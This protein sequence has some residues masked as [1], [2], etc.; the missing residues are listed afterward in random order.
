MYLLGG[1]VPVRGYLRHHREM[2]GAHAICIHDRY[3]TIKSCHCNL[4]HSFHAAVHYCRTLRHLQL[5]DN[6]LL[7]IKGL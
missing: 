6:R 1:G 4:L 5:T 3:P 2:S 7:T